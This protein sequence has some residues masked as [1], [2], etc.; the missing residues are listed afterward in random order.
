MLLYSAFGLSQFPNRL[1]V[2]SLR[3]SSCFAEDFISYAP[4]ISGPLLSSLANKS[5]NSLCI[6]D[7]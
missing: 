5:R 4:C 2:D 6:Q 7:L 1:E 3:V